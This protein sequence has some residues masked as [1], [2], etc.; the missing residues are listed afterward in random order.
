[1]KRLGKNLASLFI[2]PPAVC[3]AEKTCE[4]YSYSQCT[5]K[6]DMDTVVQ[7]LGHPLPLVGACGRG[8]GGGEHLVFPLPN[9]LFETQGKLCH[10]GVY[11]GVAGWSRSHIAV[12]N[13]QTPNNLEGSQHFVKSD[14]PIFTDL[15][16]KI[17]PLEICIAFAAKREFGSKEALIEQIQADIQSAK[18]MLSRRH[19]YGGKFWL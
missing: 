19:T 5:L 2:S 3:I 12:V 17:L 6:G 15:Y 16:G 13:T 14:S 4:Q 1:M 10:R 7:L 11:A 18:D 9:L 8:E